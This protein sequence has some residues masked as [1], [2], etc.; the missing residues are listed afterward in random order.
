MKNRMTAIG[1]DGVRYVLSPHHNKCSEAGPCSRLLQQV[2]DD[3]IF[4]RSSHVRSPLL[5][6]RVLGQRLCVMR[7]REVLYRA[8]GVRLLGLGAKL[9]RLCR[10]HE[11]LRDEV[12][13]FK[14]LAE[15]VG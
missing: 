1:I 8:G 14:V 15:V 13:I 2:I 4:F 7:G 6:K 9:E 10:A 12:G 3:A 5:D 11:E